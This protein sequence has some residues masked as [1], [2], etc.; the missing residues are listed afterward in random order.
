MSNVV[1]LLM[2]VL[3]LAGCAPVQPIYRD[4]ERGAWLFAH[5]QADT[6]P[7][8]ICHQVANGQ[9]GFSVGPNLAGIS[10]RAGTQVGGLTAEE[11]LRQS[12]LEP[13]RHIVTGYRDIMYPD[14][15][16]HLTEQDVQNLI[17]YLS[18]L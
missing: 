10:E 18:T 7:C 2:F 4:A 13:R 15:G 1:I 11:Y 8:S 17:A 9:V 14:Y 3:S 16:A 5:G 6:P 12:I